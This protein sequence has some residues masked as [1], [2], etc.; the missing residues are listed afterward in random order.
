MTAP[1][2]DVVSCFSEDVVVAVDSSAAGL[3]ASEDGDWDW[4]LLG[5]VE[6]LESLDSLDSLDFLDFFFFFF[7][8]SGE[9]G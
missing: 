1:S 5:V 8:F 3:A 9:A 2:D 7:F 6:S 4:S